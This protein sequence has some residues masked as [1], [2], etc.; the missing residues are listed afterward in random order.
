M[1][2]VNTKP[3]SQWVNRR[4]KGLDDIPVATASLNRD[5]IRVQLTNRIDNFIELRIAHVRVN[6]R[7]ILDRRRRN[8]EGTNRI[9]QISF[10]LSFS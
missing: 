4:L 1:N 5:N 10:L 2:I 9:I 7:L 8:V 6:L 3:D